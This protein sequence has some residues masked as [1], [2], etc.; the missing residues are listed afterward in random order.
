MF[1]TVGIALLLWLMKKN[2]ASA[3]TKWIRLD[4][5]KMSERTRRHSMKLTEEE[6]ARLRRQHNV[7]P[8]DIGGQ[9]G[10]HGPPKV[11]KGNPVPRWV[12]DWI[13]SMVK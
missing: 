2:V 1:T 4:G 10:Y 7:K 13:K 5:W 11:T 6:L 3:R 12:D 9:Q 8:E